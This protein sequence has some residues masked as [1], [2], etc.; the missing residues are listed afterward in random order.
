MWSAVGQIGKYYALLLAAV[1][2]WHEPL[3]WPRL[4]VPLNS[5]FSIRPIYRDFTEGFL[6]VYL[7]TISIS[8]C[9]QCRL[10]LYHFNV[11]TAL[12]V[13]TDHKKY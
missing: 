8:S 3:M 9:C 5:L 2:H 4:E 12:Q 10:C 11:S 7:M 6:P 1:K 13:N